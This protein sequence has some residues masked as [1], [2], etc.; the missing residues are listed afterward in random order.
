MLILGQRFWTY[1]LGIRCSSFQPDAFQTIEEDS[2]HS[3]E[4][5]IY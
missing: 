1:Y 2:S 5:V 4:H 3:I